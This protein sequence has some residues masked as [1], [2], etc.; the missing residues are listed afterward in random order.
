MRRRWRRSPR[1]HARRRAAAARRAAARRAGARAAR[2][3]APPR[4]AR[5]QRRRDGAH[6]RGRDDRRRRRARA[7]ARAST[8]GR[9]STGCELGPISRSSATQ[10]AGRAGRLGPGRC[11]RLWTRAEE[12]GRREHEVPEVLRV[13]LG[14]HGARA[15]GVGAPRRGGPR[16]ARRRR[17][18][19]TLERA[20]ALLV[21][22]GRARRPI[23]A[24]T[25]IGR[26]MLAL[27]VAPRLARMLVR[28]RGRRRA[29]DRA[30][31]SPR[32]RAS[33][34]SCARRRAF[35]GAG[36]RLGRR[37][38]RICCCGRSCSRRRRARVLGARR[39][40]ALGL[41]ARAVR[42][43]ERTRRQ[44][45]SRGGRGA[46]RRRLRRRSPA[47]L[48]ARRL[49]RSRLPPARARRP[50]GRHARRHGRHR[51]RPRASSATRSSSS[52][53]TSRAAS[54][55][56]KH[57]CASRAPSSVPG[58]SRCFRARSRPSAT[59]AST[60]RAAGPSARTVT[61][62][63]DLVLDDRRARR[64]RRPPR[65]RRRWPAAI[66]DDPLRPSAI[67]R[68]GRRARRPPGIPRAR[69]ARARPGG[70]SDCRSCATPSA[71]SRSG[72]RSLAELG[73]ADVVGAVRRPARSPYAHRARARRAHALDAPERPARP[74][75]LASATGRRSSPRASRRCSAW[76][77][78]RAWPPAACRSCSSCSRRTSAR[79]RSTTTSASFWRTTYA[80][81]RG[82]L[83]GRYPRHPWPD[84]P[85]TAPPTSRAKRRG[86]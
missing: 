42:A 9:G 14:A 53:S 70:G 69:D 83:R 50:A 58:S 33:A 75:R 79:C 2:R 60:R 56:A 80:Q 41:D 84:D 45:S 86:R 21:E 46:R 59:S 63:R 22:L 82:E 51:S 66:A 47:P 85:T 6:G 49:S 61:R 7:D 48:R 5:D 19:V 65:R 73:A 62:Y 28:G 68:R 64:R 77:R 3:P 25:A 43:V 29:G 11:V 17:R 37:V 52:R 44:L 81:V 13:D 1:R 18:A 34:T 16:M 38:R 20:G 30:R 26:R 39:A 74:G 8:R 72:M 78:R 67:A 71:R 24:P 40:N 57:A 31:S 10:R 55:A 35:G 23:G 27:P 54:A 76:R 12:A 15:R 32:W 36:R 4:R